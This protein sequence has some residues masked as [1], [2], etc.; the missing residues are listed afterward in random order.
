MVGVSRLAGVGSEPEGVCEGA[1][2]SLLLR[3]LEGKGK[4]TEA[5][6]VT[7][8]VERRNV[9]EEVVK[10]VGVGSWGKRQVSSVV[11]RGE[12]RWNR[13]SRFCVVFQSFG[14]GNLR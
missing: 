5:S 3:R 13:R 14:S 9:R 1:K 12:I 7:P 2:V 6:V 11:R 10:P 4:P 8:I